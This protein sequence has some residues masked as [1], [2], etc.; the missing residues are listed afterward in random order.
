[1]CS[2]KQNW[3]SVVRVW[4]RIGNLNS[5]VEKALSRMQNFLGN[6]NN[7]KKRCNAWPKDLKGSPVF[8]KRAI[9]RGLGRG[10]GHGLMILP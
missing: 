10:C 4:L 2:N 6:H 8:D 9:G 7:L 3:C 1:M 5:S